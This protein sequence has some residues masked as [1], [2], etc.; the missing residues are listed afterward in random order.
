VYG[1]STPSIVSVADELMYAAIE[2]ASV[3]AVYH[4]RHSRPIVAVAFGL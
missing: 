2:L 1:T 4:D 3:C